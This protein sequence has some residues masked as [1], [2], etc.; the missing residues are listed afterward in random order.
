MDNITITVTEAQAQQ[1]MQILT[2]TPIPAVVS[3]GLIHAVSSALM[4]RQHSKHGMQVPHVVTDQELEDA[5][6][7]HINVFNNKN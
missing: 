3:G 6:A 2:Q 7:E 5:A 4:Q 1:L